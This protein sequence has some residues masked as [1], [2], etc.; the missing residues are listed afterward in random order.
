MDDAEKREKWR[1]RYKKDVEKEVER[2]RIKVGRKCRK[3][4]AK[5]LL[6]GLQLAGKVND[7]SSSWHTAQIV[8]TRDKVCAYGWWHL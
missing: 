4:L 6:A 8:R 1:S 2:I 3:F 5:C 7:L